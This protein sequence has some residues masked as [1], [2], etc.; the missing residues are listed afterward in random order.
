MDIDGAAPLAALAVNN[1]CVSCLYPD[2]TEPERQDIFSRAVH[3][4]LTTE[5][6]RTLGGQRNLP[7]GRVCIIIMQM[8]LCF[9]IRSYSLVV[10]LNVCDKREF[11]FHQFY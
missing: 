10:N 11:E 1:K 6:R 4:V 5:A 7:G 9:M 3:R 2:Y 8:R